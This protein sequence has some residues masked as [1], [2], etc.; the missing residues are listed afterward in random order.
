M[1]ATDTTPAAQAVL[2]RLYQAA[3]PEKRLLM[4]LQMS[5]ECRRISISGIRARMPDATEGQV[6]WEVARLYL[7]DELARRVFGARSA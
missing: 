5:E 7:G 1:A 3:G 4:A 6:R 2:T